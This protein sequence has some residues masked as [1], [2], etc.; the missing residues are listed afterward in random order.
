MRNVEAQFDDATS[1][2]SFDIA[3]SDLAFFPNEGIYTRQ[4]MDGSPQAPGRLVALETSSPGLLGQSGGPIFD[5][6]GRVWAIQSRTQHIELGFKAEAE[7]NGRRIPV[8]QFMNL[9]VGVH[10]KAIIAVL[11]ELG[12]SYQ[13]SPD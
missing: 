2:F 9:G 6:E 1:T 7:V 5:A 3:A 10:A 8:P 12:V 13:V 4:I 11:D